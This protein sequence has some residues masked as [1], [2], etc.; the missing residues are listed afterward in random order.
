[1][2]I[3]IKTE[4]IMKNLIKFS[5]VFLAALLIFVGFN[6]CNED[7][8]YNYNG[9]VPVVLKI[10][11]AV[12]PMQGRHEVWTVP[13]RGGSTFAWTTEGTSVWVENPNV[14]YQWKTFI[15]YPD[16]ITVADDPE[17]VYV[18]ETTQGG[19]VSE[20]LKSDSIK[21]TVEFE[22]A[23][24]DGPAIGIVGN[25]SRYNVVLYNEGDELFSTFA[26]SIDEI[27]GEATGVVADETWNF[28][29]TFTK[30]G[31][32]ELE[33]I[34]TTTHDFK[35]TVYY[36]V[37]AIDFCSIDF[38]EI[39]GVYDG[40]DNVLLR[41]NGSSGTYPNDMTVAIKSA[42][43]RT[44]TISDGFWFGTYGPSYWGE[45]VTGG[46]AV[47]VTLND[48]GT[49]SMEDQFATQTE[50]SYDYYVSLWGAGYWTAC[51]DMIEIYIPYYMC[52]DD[53]YQE[54]L[55]GFAY[56]HLFKDLSGAKRTK[57]FTGGFNFPKNPVLEDRK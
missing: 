55:A 50:D 39:A 53:G 35:D 40:T 15:Y 7:D 31:D 28:D 27:S 34:E 10:S 52:W 25:T 54:S 51:E 14:E 19:V 30:A 41:W 42:A 23:G 44:I 43:D 36:D 32:F 49:L 18:T 20:V 26:W 21:S 57:E 5:I 45:T 22:T 6:A 56:L 24:I 48:D 13:T 33:A 2:V 9:I 29:V 16:A 12:E 47:V 3:N 1:M 11:G 46:N 8:D 37:T 38:S 4:K 17:F